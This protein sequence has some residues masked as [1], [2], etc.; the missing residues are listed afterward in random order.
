MIEFDVHVH[1]CLEGL[2]CKVVFMYK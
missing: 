1:N 2:N